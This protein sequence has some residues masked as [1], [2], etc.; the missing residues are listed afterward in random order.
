MRIQYDDMRNH[1]E[2]IIAEKYIKQTSEISY[3][4]KFFSYFPYRDSIILDL[5]RRY[6]EVLEDRD[7]HLDARV[8][9]EKQYRKGLH[10]S[11]NSRGEKPSVV[12]SEIFG[13]KIKI[14]Q[15]PESGKKDVDEYESFYQQPQVNDSNF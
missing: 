10:Q 15:L 8:E 14:S 3:F 6:A 5:R 12:D 7:G 4:L 2:K 13:E 9:I 11:L 1:L